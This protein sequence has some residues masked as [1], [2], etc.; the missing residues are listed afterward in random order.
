MTREVYLRCSINNKS[1]PLGWPF[2]LGLG[3]VR[4]GLSRFSKHGPAFMRS[5]PT[6]SPEVLN[7]SKPNDVGYFSQAIDPIM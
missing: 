2:K 5:C 6:R 3:A 1:H 7:A 4:V